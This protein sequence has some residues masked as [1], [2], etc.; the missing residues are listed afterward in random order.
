LT[1]PEAVL[2]AIGSHAVPVY[3]AEAFI[4]APKTTLQGATNSTPPV[5]TGLAVLI[6]PRATGSVSATFQPPV[7]TAS[8]NLSAPATS[9]VAYALQT[10]DATYLA[11]CHLTVGSAHLSGYA[12]RVEVIYRLDHSPADIIRHW[13]VS[14]VYGTLPSDSSASPVSVNYMPDE[15]DNCS[16]TFDTKGFP[17]GR[18]SVEGGVQQHYGVQVQ[19]RSDDYPDGWTR[20]QQFKTKLT[21]EVNRSRVSI[22]S[23]LYEIQA[24]SSLG[25]P[26]FS[27]KEAGTKRFRFAADFKTALIQLIQT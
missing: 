14:S 18:E 11:S 20:I 24:V 19:V 15:P 2:S 23:S 9:L 6:A 3:T 10:S 1:V 22:G 8:G 17:E 12:A 7:Q 25:S 26:R 27:G 13:I 21:E 16:C 4:V 5:Y